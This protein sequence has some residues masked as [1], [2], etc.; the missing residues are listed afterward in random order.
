MSWS[1]EGAHHRNIN[2]AHFNRKFSNCAV[3]CCRTNA[4]V[5]GIL[6][7][8][9]INVTT[10]KICYSLQFKSLFC[11]QYH[12]VWNML[13]QVQNLHSNYM[14]LLQ[15]LCENYYSKFRMDFYEFSSG[16]LKNPVKFLK[17]KKIFEM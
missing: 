7:I 13:K 1:N 17:N 15:V 4:I 14:N 5:G 9:V 16:F 3:H 11:Q 2:Y 8:V 6:V 12:F 10:S